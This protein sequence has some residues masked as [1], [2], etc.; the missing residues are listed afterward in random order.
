[1]SV[2]KHNSTAILASFATLK[3]LLDEKKYK[4]SY[5]VLQEFIH[6][7]I[8]NESI[9]SF[10]AIEIK[11]HL[12]N[13]FGFSIPE[14]VIKT[15]AKK[16]TG[17]QLNNGSY[18]VRFEELGNDSLFQDKKKEA[19]QTSL[20]IIKRLSQY[21]LSKTDNA[22][23]NENLLI[24]KLIAFLVDDQLVTSNKYTDLISE[25]IIKNENDKKIQNELDSIREGSILYL[26]LS[27]N[28]CETGSISKPLNLYL[29]TEILF[30][31]AGFNGTI[32][33]QLANDFLEQVKVANTNGQK[34]ISL[35]YFVETKNEIDEFFSVAEE[36]ADGKIHRYIDRP[37][38]K[39]IINGCNSS[40]DVT[41]K[42][43]DF[44]HKLKFQ[45][46]ILQDEHDDYYDEYHF[47]SNLESLDEEN[48]SDKSKKKEEALRLVSHINKLREGERFSSDLDSKYLLVTNTKA[49]LLISGEQ[50]TTIKEEEDLETL[51]NFA[52]SLD[53]ITSLLWYKLGN[54]FTKQ[55]FPSNLSVIISARI[56]LS[57][58]IA[59]RADRAFSE[60]KT[61]YDAG[62]ITEEQVAARIIT[63]KD[64]PRLPE[65]LQGDDIEQIMDFSPEY[66]SR[67]EEEFKA[68]QQA[69]KQ[70][71]EIIKS[72]DEEREKGYSVRDAK[73]ANQKSIIEEK[74]NE[75]KKLQQ[76]IEK[77]Q[78]K[79]DE[80]K[81]TQQKLDEYRRKE[82]EE[83]RKKE[84]RKRKIRFFLSI[85]WKFLVLAVVTTG[86]IVLEKVFNCPVVT[87]AAIVIDCLAFITFI[88]TTIKRDRKKYLEDPDN[89]KIKVIKTGEDKKI[90]H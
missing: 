21:I 65:E 20:C 76:E 1:M 24:Q 30:S 72:L 86:A 62:A 50:T 88:I 42:K 32:Y 54:S 38:M 35:F 60:I 7:I 5:Q 45:F 57:S 52:V 10:T 8:I 77:Y 80:H 2:N 33:Q 58:S 79:E 73:I 69:V 9:F 90:I 63:L 66:L 46:G 51:C 49:A 31:I 61:Q 34:K 12:Y 81:K 43:S 64:K 4:S 53:R 18:T 87:T 68:N 40:T 44:Y 36:I 19:D 13:Y 48:D 56:V 28:I 67:Y 16:M 29:S 39:A 25:Y 89:P 85:T 23:I 3:S 26:G 14:A 70:K 71:D 17:V 83:K 55:S 75:N 41:V 11:N 15:A 82:N 47:S 22:S 78:K 59:K 37:A 84:K 74:N 6:Y 27:Y